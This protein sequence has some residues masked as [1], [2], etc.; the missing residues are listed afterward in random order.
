MA[1]NECRGREANASRSKQ[2]EAW[3]LLSSGDCKTFWF[4]PFIL[5]SSL[6]IKIETIE[7]YF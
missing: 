4:A 5:C 1:L 6:V 3:L 7:A 2:N